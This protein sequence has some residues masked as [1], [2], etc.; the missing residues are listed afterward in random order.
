M[1]KD[2]ETKQAILISDSWLAELQKHP[3]H[4]SK[5]SSFIFIGKPGT[6]VFLLKESAKLY[7]VPKERK[8]F[9]LSKRLSG[10]GDGRGASEAPNISADKRMKD[11]TGKAVSTTGLMMMKGTGHP[12]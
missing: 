11:N 3:Y 10:A 6:A 8:Q 1:D 5:I 7:K 4:S 12:Q 2:E 9:M